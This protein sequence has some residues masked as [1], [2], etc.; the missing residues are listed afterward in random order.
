[1]INSGLNVPSPAMPMPAL[2]VPNAAPTAVDTFTS[3]H[4]IR[5]LKLE[6]NERVRTAEYHLE[7]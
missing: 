5:G 1:M 4:K 7:P 3:L 2:D 6:L